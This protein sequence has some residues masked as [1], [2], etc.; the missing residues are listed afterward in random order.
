MFADYHMHTYLCKHAT[1]VPE[2]YVDRARALGLDEIAFTDHVPIPGGYDPG[3]RMRFDQFTD[4]LKLIRTVAA[5][6]GLPVL[7]GLE[8][9]YHQNTLGFLREWL[10]AQPM[11]LILGSVHYI[12]DWEFDNPAA[13]ARWKSADVAGAW[14]AYFQRIGELADT[15]L[16]DVVAH[17]D[18][19]KKFGFRPRDSVIREIVA[20]S[21]DRIAA[22]G[23][24]IELNT[25]GLRRPVK[26]IYPSQ[27]ILAMARKRGIPICLGSDAHAPDDVGHA[28]HAALAWARQA[29][30]TE[31]VRFRNRT[32]HRSP[33]PDAPAQS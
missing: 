11:D 14:R 30:Y 21:L 26:E 25:S 18:L 19:P 15:G 32:I 2:D 8:A 20:P 10:P 22:A 1:G 4:Y 5:R 17:L 31:W 33:L 28:F 3:N 13:M 29:G 12:D 27:D 23:M 7:L 16:F 24:V 9:D 6:A